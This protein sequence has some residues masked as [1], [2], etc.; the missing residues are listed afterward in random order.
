MWTARDSGLWCL[1]ISDYWTTTLP[2]ALWALAKESAS[3]G[4]QKWTFGSSKKEINNFSTW[5]WSNKR[6]PES[7]SVHSENI[8]WSI[9]VMGERSYR[10]T[11]SLGP[12]FSVKFQFFFCPLSMTISFCVIWS[13][14]W[15]LSL[16]FLTPDLS[17]VF[18]L[19]SWELCL[20]WECF[21]LFSCSLVTVWNLEHPHTRP[22]L[23]PCATQKHS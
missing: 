23:S 15:T 17:Q 14:Y 6:P 22:R 1:S 21:P 4:S 10:M 11:E 5:C 9:R 20:I 13:K 12:N 2:R 19:I 18:W 16:S 7:F 3:Q 8:F